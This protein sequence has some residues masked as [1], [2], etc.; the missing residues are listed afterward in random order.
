VTNLAKEILKLGSLRSVRGA[1]KKR[2]RIGRGPG[3]GHGKTST[4]GH[5]GQLARAGAKK[6]AWF[7]GG[8]MPLSRRVPKRGFTSLR[9]KEFQ[10]VNLKSLVLCPKD[11]L[12]TPLLLKNLGLIKKEDQPVKILGEGEISFPIT[13]QA[14]AFSKTAKQRIEAGGGKA[15]LIK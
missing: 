5:K 1:T 9:N 4:R 2:K 10:I 8:Q 6:R 7:E 15:E 13:V 12:V 3:S 14:H 11:Q